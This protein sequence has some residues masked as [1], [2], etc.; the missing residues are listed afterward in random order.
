MIGWILR[1]ALLAL[2]GKVIGG[3]FRGDDDKKR[4]KRESRAESEA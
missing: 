2:A 3:M 1:F 4:A